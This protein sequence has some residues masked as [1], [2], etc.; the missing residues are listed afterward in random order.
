M[1]YES[2]GRSVA[3][4][5]RA[6][7]AAGLLLLGATTALA[8]TIEVKTGDTGAIA[9]ATPVVPASGTAA[10]T[11]ATLV[12]SPVQDQA[13]TQRPEAMAE[14][15]DELEEFDPPPLQMGD[16]TRGLFA[17]QRSGDISSPTP[18]PITGATANR[19]YER[20]LKSFD[21]PIPERMT[22]SVKASS[23]GGGNSAK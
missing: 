18:R 10:A 15:A 11:A 21:F 5:T 14:S 9:A 13:A 17:W 3:V 22:S 23:G 2:A 16:A 4:P 20:Y 6:I 7:L 1:N 8:Q 12:D 19:S